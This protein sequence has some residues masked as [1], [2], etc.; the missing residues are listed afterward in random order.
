MAINAHEQDILEEVK[1]RKELLKPL[2]SQ[3]YEVNWNEH[4]TRYTFLDP[5]LRALGWDLSDPRQVRIEASNSS[6]ERADYLLYDQQ[7]NLKI[8]VEAKRVSIGDIDATLEYEGFA[9]EDD[10]EWM[11]WSKRELSQIG[12]YWKNYQPGL[13]V[14]TSG[15][16]WDIYELPNRR[17]K[18]ETKRVN[19]FNLLSQP[20]ADYMTDLMRLHRRNF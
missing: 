15:I 13:A 20:A 18:I 7:K 10:L 6:R 4:Q 9:A 3:N 1:R 19:Y 16:F 5:V 17:G 8:V 11:E 14:L 2:K 12:N